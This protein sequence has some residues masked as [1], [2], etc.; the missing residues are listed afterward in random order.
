MVESKPT[1]DNISIDISKVNPSIENLATYFKGMNTC[2]T[3]FV[4]GLRSCY[5]EG[6]SST[7]EYITLR[8]NI[9][10]DAILYSKNVI[11]AFKK[12]LLEAKDFLSDFSSVYKKPEELLADIDS[13]I[14]ESGK[15]YQ[16]FAQLTEMQGVFLK[17]VTAYSKKA[18]DLLKSFEMSKTELAEKLTKLD[19]TVQKCEVHAGRIGYWGNFMMNI[20]IVGAILT[21]VKIVADKEASEAKHAFDVELESMETDEQACLIMSKYLVPT[22]KDFGVVLCNLTKIFGMIHEDALVMKGSDKKESKEIM[23]KTSKFLKALTPVSREAAQAC[24]FCLQILVVMEPELAGIEKFAM[25]K[26]GTWIEAWKNQ[27]VENEKMIKKELTQIVKSLSLEVLRGATK[28]GSKD[29]PDFMKV[30]SSNS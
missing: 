27:H 1:V 6:D 22:L 13:V 12:C 25:E 14:K 9:T 16:D 17:N 24:A 29:G 19:E 26:K 23:D 5:H 8:G 21:G 4:A 2:F 20:P 11:P 3:Q 18:N 28:E 30:F 10:S 15:N 7:P